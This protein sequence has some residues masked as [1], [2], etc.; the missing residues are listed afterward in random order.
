MS[1]E[2]GNKLVAERTNAAVL[3][4]SA[5]ASSISA[6]IREEVETAIHEDLV[7]LDNDFLMSAEVH[8]P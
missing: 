6:G 3:Q 7:V 5:F 8:E 1:G 4:R 2:S